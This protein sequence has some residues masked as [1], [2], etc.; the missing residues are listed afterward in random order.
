MISCP[1]EGGASQIVMEVTI[2]LPDDI[3]RTLGN[4]KEMPR[5]VLEAFV[6]EA[7]REQ[8]LSRRQLS[9]VLGYDYWQT[10]EFLTQ[11]EAR[12]PFTLADLQVDRNS[13]A[14]LPEK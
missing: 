1:A 7:Y 4:A 10:E 6:A 11:H 8:R 12:R 9:Q 13:L 2:E 5:K 3:A 14:S